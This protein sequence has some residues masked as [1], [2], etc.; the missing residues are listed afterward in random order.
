MPALVLNIII[1]LTENHDRKSTELKALF[2]GPPKALH[3]GRMCTPGV[4]RQ[5]KTTSQRL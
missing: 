1:T 5:V 3:R 4:N 2:L